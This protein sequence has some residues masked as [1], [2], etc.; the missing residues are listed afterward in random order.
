MLTGR[1]VSWFL[2]F[3]GSIVSM[4]VAERL[5]MRIYSVEAGL[6]HGHVS[7]I[8]RDSRGF[9]WFCTDGG[10]SR[11]DGYRFQTYT[12]A[13][14]LPHAHVDDL[15]E[16]RRGQYWVATDQGL[17]RF[18]PESRSAFSTYF[19]G[20]SS[21]SRSVNILLEDRDGSVL[22]GTSDGLYRLVQSSAEV[23][24]VRVDLQLTLGQRDS[25][26]INSLLVTQDGQLW[27]GAGSGLYRHGSDG[28]WEHFSRANGLRENFV[29]QVRQDQS[30]RLW[31]GTRGGG[32][33]ELLRNPRSGRT[34]VGHVFTR[35]DGLPSDDVRDCFISAEGSLWVG[36][37]L[38]LAKASLAAFPHLHFQVHPIA[39][40]LAEQSVYWFAESEAGDLWIATSQIGAIRVSRQQFH[41]Y[42]E[43][44]GFLPQIANQVV[45]T[46]D[47]DLCV[48]NGDN[49]RRLVQSFDGQRF[50]ARPLHVMTHVAF[51]YEWQQF[52]LQD[53]RRNWWLAAEPGLLRIA[54]FDKA[55]PI[56]RGQTVS[57]LTNLK[58]VRQVFQDSRGAMWI[59]EEHATFSDVAAWFP[60][61]GTIHVLWK[62]FFLPGRKRTATSFFIEDE[63]GQIW[64][65]LTGEGGV[66]RWRKNH[67]EQF[68]VER[69]RSLKI[70]DPQ[71][72][73]NTGHQ[74]PPD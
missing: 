60:S 55:A 10:L 4:A 12:T 64:A 49:G 71:C 70:G 58:N 15:L 44:D 53:R 2:A 31:V 57:L 19:P 7:R 13:D 56:A 73:L 50:L 52:A 54:H 33:I 28:K 23:R 22:I 68:G 14:G 63:A 65:G 40:G 1:C 72:E 21:L 25:A 32:L 43:A 74:T 35:R 30:G 8:R 69:Y 36:T 41:S 5:P 34:D 6:A 20:D 39:Q 24:I 11:W 26:L 27:V 48:V 29:N 3:S 17:A 42:S 62:K 9:L 46:V 18:Q 16:T 66:L 51:G 67:F 61:T 47:G 37:R 59:G 45:E 38:G